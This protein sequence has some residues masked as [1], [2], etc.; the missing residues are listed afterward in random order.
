M[1]VRRIVAAGLRKIRLDSEAGS[2]LQSA[3]RLWSSE[4][5]L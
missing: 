5:V 3:P 4:R 1:A 2:P